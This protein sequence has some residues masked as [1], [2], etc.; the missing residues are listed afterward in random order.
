M[1][2][3][4]PRPAAVHPENTRLFSRPT[5]TADSNPGDSN[6][7]GM[8]NGGGSPDLFVW[9]APSKTDRALEFSQIGTGVALNYA[10]GGF[11]KGAGVLGA[12]TGVAT[13][14]SGIGDLRESKTALDYV[15]TAGALAL[16]VDGILIGAHGIHGV[17]AAQMSGGVRN[18]S[19]A[20]GTIYGLSDLVVG[21][22]DFVKGREE[23]DSRYAGAGLLQAGMGAAVLVSMAFPKLAPIADGVLLAT[24]VGRDAIFH[25][26]ESQSR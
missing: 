3:G 15:S 6:G 10:T 26:K 4:T 5:I 16:G 20:L 19:L 17:T 1:K 18:T 11:L 22:V 21:A 7:S 23:K 12:V 9:Q 8:H 2:I 13:L 14:A 24:L 25:N